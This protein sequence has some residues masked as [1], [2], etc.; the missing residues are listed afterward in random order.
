MA[1]NQPTPVGRVLSYGTLVRV[2]FIVVATI[3]VVA[4]LNMAFGLPSMGPTFQI[5]PDPAGPLPY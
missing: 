5:V 2:L 4:A 3:I 1:L